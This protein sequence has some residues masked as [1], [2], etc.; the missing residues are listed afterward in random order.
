MTEPHPTK[1]SER[2]ARRRELRQARISAAQ[3]RRAN[4]RRMTIGIVVLVVLLLAVGAWFAFTT[5]V[6]PPATG[7]VPAT[8]PLWDSAW[9]VRVEFTRLLEDAAHAASGLSL[10]WKSETAAVAWPVSL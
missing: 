1:A 2:I 6:M 7:M 9:Q 4:R 10:S 3:R 8:A 5:F